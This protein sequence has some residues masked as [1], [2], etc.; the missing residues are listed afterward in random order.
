MRNELRHVV[1]AVAIGWLG[2]CASDPGGG[3]ESTTG[4]TA[5]STG[6]AAT[7]STS[8]AS[9]STGAQTSTSSAQSTGSVDTTSGGTSTGQESTQG[10]TTAAGAPL[11][12]FETTMGDIVIEL[13]D[14]A[15]PVTAANFVA[16]VEAG[17][18]DGADGNGA[19]IFH[20]VIPGFVIQG[21][22]LTED[23][24]TK[25]TMAPIVNEFGNG[26]TNKRATIS[27][28]RTSDPDSATSQ[29]FINLVDNASLDEPPGYAVFGEVIEGMDVVDAIATVET[30]T[31]G[32]YDDVP[33]E[34]IVITSAT[35]N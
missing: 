27:M 18:Y 1:L 13:D 14:V 32:P 26:L 35:V 12:T 2:S 17:F 31:M 5:G 24:D 21:G 23:L 28:A 30:T 19:T 3:G 4:E 33:V 34:P 29:F 8:D 25:A 16:Y 15:A 10:S 7:G 11:V 20:R 9:T 22:G 6:G